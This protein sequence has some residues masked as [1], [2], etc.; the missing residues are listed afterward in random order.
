MSF[1]EKIITII[2]L[3]FC[4]VLF[5]NI[6]FASDSYEENSTYYKDE[7]NIEFSNERVVNSYGVDEDF[8]IISI[9]PDHK[10]ISID[11]V[12][13][14]IPGAYIEFAVDIVNNGKNNSK[15]DDLYVS[16]FEESNAIK[17][18]FLNQEEIYNKVLQPKEKCT[19][20]FRIEWDI[21]ACVTSDES[22]SFNIQIPTSFVK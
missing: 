2:A 21:N 11:S 15:I 16:G 6:G 4:T 9:S 13:L 3:L 19:I 14:E 1:K 20:C 12:N 10:N 22:T 8:T 7:Y 5:F 17:F 18:S